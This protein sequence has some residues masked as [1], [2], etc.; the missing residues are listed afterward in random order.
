MH[1]GRFLLLLF[2]T[3]LTLAAADLDAVRK[4]H[5]RGDYEKALAAA[6]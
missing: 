3:P 1:P 6:R 4:L 5:A 2:L